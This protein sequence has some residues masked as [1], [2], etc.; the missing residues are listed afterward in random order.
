MGA[1]L[2]LGARGRGRTTPNPNVGCVIVKEGRVIGRGW[3][4][5]GGRPHAEAMALAQAG[6][7][8]RGATLYVT[9]EPCAH[10]SERGPACADLIAE[11]GVARV[12]AAVEDPDSRTA[13]RGFERLRAAGV[14]G[15]SGVRQA[16]ALRSFAGF[17]AR[18]RHGRPHVTLKLATSLDGRIALPDGSSRWI[19]G[20]PARAHA[21]LE[22][23]RHEA[24][25]VG[26]GTWEADAPKLDVR[27]E[28]L[29]GRSP[30][31]A[32]LARHPRESGGPP[33]S[34]APPMDEQVGPGFRR[35]VLWI[36]SPV[37]VHP[38]PADHLLVEG[39]AETAAAF[40]SADLVDRLLLYRA[41]ILIGAGK[42]AIGDIGLADLADAHGRWHLLDARQLGSDRLEVYERRR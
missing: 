39:G 35:D 15:A 23:S 30:I 1:A 4:Q 29:E 42:A 38:L 13:G 14:A 40:L 7:E 18:Q 5:P 27:L 2:A 8:S 36:D 19:T 9:L 3:T 10:R 33:S 16:E 21:H 28:G 41:P 11:A 20:E 22:R 32:I 12:V 17:I 25:L 34:S 31:R 37:R 24:I 6:A 26:R